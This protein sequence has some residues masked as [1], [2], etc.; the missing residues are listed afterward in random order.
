[1]TSIWKLVEA[2]LSPE[3]KARIDMAEK[4]QQQLAVAAATG[5]NPD[6]N[7]S[8]R[9]NK[10]GNSKG[11]SGWSNNQH[12]HR[13]GSKHRGTYY[14]DTPETRKLCAKLAVEQM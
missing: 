5:T 13:Q 7:Y 1:M 11:S 9:I 10:G 2:E 3:A 14:P 6:K 8:S 12:P 4:K